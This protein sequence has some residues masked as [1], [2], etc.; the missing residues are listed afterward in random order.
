MKMP[1]PFL[2]T[3]YNY[4]MNKAGDESALHCEDPPLTKQSFVEESDINTIV[5]R[6]HLTGELPTNIRMPEY[7][8]FTSVNDFHT[9][10]NAIAKANESFDAMPAEVRA[11]FHNDP[12]E[13][14]EFCSDSR[15][16]DEARKLGLVP[17]KELAQAQALAIPKTPPAEPEPAAA[18]PKKGAKE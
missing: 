15:N 12:A 10:L 4:D 6:F 18:P 1:L 16:L 9:A 8:D 2:R 14:V 11:R 5:R 3:T 7:G 13:F 17:E